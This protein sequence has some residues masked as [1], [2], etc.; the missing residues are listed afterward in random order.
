MSPRSKREYREAVHINDTPNPMLMR[1]LFGKKPP[2]LTVKPGTAWAGEG[3]IRLMFID[4]ARFGR[5]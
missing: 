5:R 4:K 1:K 2:D 3:P